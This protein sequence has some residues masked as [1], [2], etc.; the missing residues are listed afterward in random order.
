VLDERPEL[1][2]EP[3]VH[4]LPVDGVPLGE[5][6]HKVGRASSRHRQPNALVE[7]HPAHQAPVDKVLVAAPR[8]PDSG[9]GTIPVVAQPVDHPREF[10][11]RRVVELEPGLVGGIDGVHHLAVDVQLDLVGRPVADPHRT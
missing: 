1:G 8:F 10:D 6:T 9:L 11:P 4:D 7:R 3:L 5:P 2:I